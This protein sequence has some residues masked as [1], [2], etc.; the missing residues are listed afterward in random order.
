MPTKTFNLVA[1][2]TAD[3]TTSGASF[4][5]L[6]GT[7]YTNYCII[8]LC[9]TVG[10]QGSYQVRFNSVAG[11]N[12]GVIRWIIN[13]AT[14]SASETDNASI[15]TIGGSAAIQK[16][17]L[18]SCLAVMDFANE[19]SGV[20]YTNLNA[21]YINASSNEFGFMS[22]Q[23]YPSS[24]VTSSLLVTNSAGVNFWTGSVIYLFGIV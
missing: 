11:T 6:S 2:Y 16:D 17:A 23:V 8:A 12:Y 18:G 21:K 19:T 3:G 24:A 7:G 14:P 1:T 15:W 22:G 10:S 13:S 20:T 5:G 9:A 4:S